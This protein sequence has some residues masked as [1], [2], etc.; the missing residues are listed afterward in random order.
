VTL[1]TGDR[2]RGRTEIPLT[3]FS[4][5]ALTLVRIG[6]NYMLTRQVAHGFWMHGAVVLDTNGLPTAARVYL[7][8]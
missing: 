4:F 3:H 5:G 1:I 7:I 2:R 6:C 8:V